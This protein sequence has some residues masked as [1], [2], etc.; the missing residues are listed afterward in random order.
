MFLQA[1]LL[2]IIIP[3]FNDQFTGLCDDYRLTLFV[4]HKKGFTTQKAEL[5]LATL[6]WFKV[7]NIVSK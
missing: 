6:K 1:G 5:R 2:C 4:P 7:I 3:E